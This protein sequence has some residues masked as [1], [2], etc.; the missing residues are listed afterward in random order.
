MGRFIRRRMG[1][2]YKDHTKVSPKYQHKPKPIVFVFI[3]IPVTPPRYLSS[4]DPSCVNYMQFSD[5]VESVFTTKNLERTPTAE[6]RQFVPR[7]EVD[8]S[9]LLP[10]EEQILQKTMHRLAE[11]V[12]GAMNFLLLMVAP[13]QVLHT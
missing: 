12:G 11:K 3:L 8:P 2:A 10:E 9:R 13:R 6:V 1:Y 4:K 7:P 5:E